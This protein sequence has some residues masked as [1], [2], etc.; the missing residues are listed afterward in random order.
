MFKLSRSDRF[1]RWK[2]FRQNL[3]LLKLSDAIAETN[4]LWSQCPYRPY[5]LD[6]H[7]NAMWPDPWQLIDENIYCDIAKTLGMLYTLHL[8]EHR[9]SLD[10]ELR[11]YQNQKNQYQYH[12]AYFCHG[13]YVLNLIEGDV[14]NKEHIN[15]ELKLIRCYTASDLKLEQY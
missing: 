10:P 3:S 14:V 9:S 4:D 8:T 15:Q 11:I 5:Y 12:I 6:A 13:K 7:D 1:N 2:S